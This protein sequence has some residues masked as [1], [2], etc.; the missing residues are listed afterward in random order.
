MTCDQNSPTETRAAS[1]MLEKIKPSLAEL[2]KIART[3]LTSYVLFMSDHSRNEWKE[4]LHS[5]LFL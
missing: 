5:L 1:K 2:R 3:I 4:H